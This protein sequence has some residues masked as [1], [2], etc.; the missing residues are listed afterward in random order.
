MTDGRRRFR[1]LPLTLTG[2]ILG[3][4]G[5]GAGDGSPGGGGPPI[6]AV[7]TAAPVRYG[8]TMRIELSGPGVDASMSFQL[9]GACEG[10]PVGTLE[11]SERL[12]AACTPD[13]LGPLVINAINAAGDVLASKSLTVEAPIVALTIGPAAS[14]AVFEFR[15][16]PGDRRAPQRPW[17]DLFLYR[18][19]AGEYDL[20]VM[21]QLLGGVRIEGGCYLQDPVG[22]AREWSSPPMPL[23]Q[24]LAAT[25]AQYTLAMSADRCLAR[26]GLPQA[27]IFA[28]NLA[29][30]SALSGQLTPVDRLNYVV[31]GRLDSGDRIRLRGLSDLITV[32]QTTWLPNFPA[33]PAAATVRTVQRRR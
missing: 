5:G 4:C 30:N 13:L 1:L 8:D 27:G 19:K 20:S 29:D 16:D 21:H 26:N 18:L 31:I 9:S 23:V 12:V 6:A 32:S 7:I 24:Q 3:A 28:I 33:D 17:V 22:Q 25:N 15:L 2:L 10:R 11:G 14:P